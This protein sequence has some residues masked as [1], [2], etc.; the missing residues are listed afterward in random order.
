MAIPVPR[1]RWVHVLIYDKLRG[2]GLVGRINS[3]ADMIGLPEE[4]EEFHPRNLSPCGVRVRRSSEHKRKK[5][6]ELIPVEEVD[7]FSSHSG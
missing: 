7:I 2:W 6:C 3:R 1:K 5:P 4:G